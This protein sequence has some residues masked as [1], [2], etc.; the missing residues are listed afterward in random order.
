M[1]LDDLS[2]GEAV[3]LDANILIYHFTS[4]PKYGL[5]CTRLVERIEQK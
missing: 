2:A 1:I 4:H 5:A 3:F